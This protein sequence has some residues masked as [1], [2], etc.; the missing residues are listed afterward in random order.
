MISYSINE[1]EKLTGIKAHTIRMWEKRYHVFTP[2]RTE[3]NI[4]YYDDNDLKKLLNISTLNRHGVKISTIAKMNE[5]TIREKVN[6]SSEPSLIQCFSERTRD[7]IQIM[8]KNPRNLAFSYY[9]YK[10][11]T[12][13]GRGYSDSLRISNRLRHCFS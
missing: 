11:N 9:I 8:V 12:E 13:K 10:K 6:L 1:L 5:D 7:S 4:R 2:Q 3:T